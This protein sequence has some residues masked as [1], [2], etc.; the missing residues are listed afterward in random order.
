MLPLRLHVKSYAVALL[1][2]C[3]SPVQPLPSWQ[4]FERTPVTDS[5]A[6][7]AG[8]CGLA[9]GRLPVRT[10]GELR[11]WLDSLTPLGGY[12]PGPH[13]VVQRGLEGHAQLWAHEM[14]H[15]AQLIKGT[16][17]Q[18]QHNAEYRRLART[19]CKEMCWDIKAFVG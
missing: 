1:A 6:G 8:S 19:V 17:T 11:L 10:Y 16:A 13:V 12:A 9:D 15:A 7:I 3:S 5:A 14:L 2:C 18:S 4:P